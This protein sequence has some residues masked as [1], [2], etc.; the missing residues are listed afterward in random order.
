MYCI[1]YNVLIIFTFAKH[2]ME[3]KCVNLLMCLGH[4]FH[5]SVTLSL[6]HLV[7]NFQGEHCFGIGYKALKIREATNS[8]IS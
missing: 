5:F 6:S 2:I 4:F 1:Y 3:E 7:G 8:F